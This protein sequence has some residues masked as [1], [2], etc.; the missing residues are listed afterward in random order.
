MAS[1]FELVPSTPI[2]CQEGALGKNSLHQRNSRVFSV[3]QRYARHSG[4][5]FW[6]PA[7][8]FLDTPALSSTIRQCCK[9]AGQQSDNLDIPG[10]YE[11]YWALETQLIASD[12]K[13]A[14]YDQLSN[15]KCET[16]P[17]SHATKNQN[18]SNKAAGLNFWNLDLLVSD[19]DIRF[20]DFN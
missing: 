10:N 3:G 8:V 15:S 13:A 17:Q 5:S 20:S 12:A 19:F 16:R 14:R 2:S 9:T 11:E 6:I 4:A 18:V 7:Y 1:L